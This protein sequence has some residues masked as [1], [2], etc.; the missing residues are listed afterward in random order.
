MVAP[1]EMWDAR[2]G[3][4]DEYGYGT[5][6]NQ[7]LAERFSKEVAALPAGARCLM[8][9]EGEGRNAVALA[10]LGLQVTGVDIAEAGLSKARKLATERGV[11]VETVVADLGEYEYGKEKWDLIVGIFCHV[12]PPI[13]ERMLSRIPPA[14]TPGGYFILECYTPAQL[15]LKTG[16]PPVAELTY[17]AKLLEEALGGSLTIV[18]NEEVVREVVEGVWHTGKGAV[19]Q[20]IGKKAE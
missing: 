13:R 17:T 11:T 18:R 19:V 2:Y 16:G 9:A 10:E 12:P 15:D 1:K 7:F 14:L 6:P 20:F 3:S 5:A 4:T 8:L